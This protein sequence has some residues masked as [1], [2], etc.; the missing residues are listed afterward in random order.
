[1]LFKYIKSADIRKLMSCTESKIKEI[2]ADCL[3]IEDEDAENKVECV[4]ELEFL[5]R[6]VL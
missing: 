3:G 4:V 2:L 5:E 6:N 1:M